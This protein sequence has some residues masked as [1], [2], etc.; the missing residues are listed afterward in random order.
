MTLA[1]E[2]MVVMGDREVLQLEDNWTI[3]TADGRPAAHFEHTIAVTENGVD[4]LTDGR[5]PWGL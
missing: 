4:V 2:P 3:I 1:I 5:A